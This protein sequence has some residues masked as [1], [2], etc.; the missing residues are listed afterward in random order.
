MDI[1]GEIIQKR[2]R[3]KN[4]AQSVAKRRKKRNDPELMKIREARRA[5]RLEQE[6]L[7]AKDEPAPIAKQ[8]VA[9]EQPAQT[10]GDWISKLSDGDLA[11]YYETI[12]G[13]KPPHNVT[14]QKQE[15]VVRDAQ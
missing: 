9:K 12:K 15:T 1:E 14:R 11:G 13:N 3:R 6:A 7:L 4:R 10:Q 5:L 2:G 8:A